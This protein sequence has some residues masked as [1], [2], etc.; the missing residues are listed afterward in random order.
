MGDATV[1]A[2]D[3]ERERTA[4]LLR[5][6]A[7]CGRLSG[8]EL[9][10]RLDA[11]FAARTRGELAVLVGDLPATPPARRHH[12]SLRHHARSFVLVNAL[13]VVLWLIDGAGYFWP[14]WPMF[15]WGI[16]LASHALG[17]GGRRSMTLGPW[18][19]RGHSPTG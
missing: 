6:H 15:G 4:T 11:A 1:R 13:L 7:G 12:S 9:S 17:A 16:G 3:D 10:D 5:E 18:R 2:S 14:A 8:D 19:A